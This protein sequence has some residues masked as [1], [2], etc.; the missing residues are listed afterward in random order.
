MFAEYVLTFR[1]DSTDA[2]VDGM[3][4]AE[5]DRIVDELDEVV[6]KAVGAIRTTLEERLEVDVVFELNGEPV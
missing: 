5:R 1:G 2:V 6:A 3:T 4:H